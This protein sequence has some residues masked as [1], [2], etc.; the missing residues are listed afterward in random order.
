MFADE[1]QSVEKRWRQLD[2]RGAGR[3]LAN[4][5]APTTAHGLAGIAFS[6]GGIR[7]ATINLGIAQGRSKDFAEARKSFQ[8]A[9]KIDATDPRVPENL[10]ELAE[11]EAIAKGGKKP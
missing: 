9:G 4:I 11:A 3:G 5:A 6:G 7:S 8:K 2:D 1:L 10:K